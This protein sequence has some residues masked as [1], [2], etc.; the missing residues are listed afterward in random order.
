MLENPFIESHGDPYWRT[1]VISGG[2]HLGLILILVLFP[3]IYYEKLPLTRFTKPEVLAY[4]SPPPA[5]PA[6]PES[7]AP[8][9]TKSSQPEVVRLPDFVPPLSRL[10]GIPPP[11]SSTADLPA[12]TVF[13]T[14]PGPYPDSGSRGGNP[15]GLPAGVVESQGPPPPPPTV[16]KPIRVSSGAVAAR[17]IHRVDPVYPELAIRARLEGLVL[18]QVLINE[19]GAVEEVSVISGPPM[20]RDSAVKAVRQ[21]EYTPTILNGDPV[22]VRATVT[23][24]FVL[25]R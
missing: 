22:P 6:P 3:L 16:K 9:R 14:R 18:L 12:S 17:L 10:D 19:E 15:V 20:L 7:A 4:M 11:D 21:W 2:I 23:V 24:N 25:H 1:L 8:V 13:A 5:P